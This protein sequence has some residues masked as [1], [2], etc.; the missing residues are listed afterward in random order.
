MT[1]ATNNDPF[2]SF[3]PAGTSGADLTALDGLDLSQ[4][5]VAE[6]FSFRAPEPGFHNA[7]VTKTECRLSSKGLPMAVLTYA[8]D[9]TN[10][11]DHGV[12][13]LGYTVLYFKRTEQGR[14]TRVLNPGFRRMLEAVLAHYDARGYAA[15]LPEGTRYLFDLWGRAIDAVAS[16]DHAGIATEIDWA[17]KLALVERYMRRSG[18][19]LGDPR[20]ARLD[21]AYHDV[22]DAGLRASMES[23]GLLRTFT[24]P[25]AAER[26]SARP[27]QNTRAKLRGEFVAKA[28]RLRF[29]Y[30]VD[31]TNLRLLEV[32][33]TRTVVLKDPFSSADERVDALMDKMER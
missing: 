2:A 11:P 26:A 17:A 33:G 8:I 4:V 7:V 12:V 1:T 14:T 31:W 24:G 20:L 19:E 10:D 30:A 25:G 3:A 22:T 15:D 5:E 27:P 16:G 23:A 9:D 6:E 21:L 18:A 28:R 13:V 32:E 29:D